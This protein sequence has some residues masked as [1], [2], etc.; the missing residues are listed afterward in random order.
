MKIRHI[1]AFGLRGGTPEGGW[2]DELRPEDCVHTLI[3]VVAGDGGAGAA[4]SPA[5]IW[6]VHRLRCFGLSTRA[7][8]RSWNPSA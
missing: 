8:K 6:F 4:Y 5:K 3:A 2:S 1:H 7:R